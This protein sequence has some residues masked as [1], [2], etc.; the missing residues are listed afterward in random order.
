MSYT[1]LDLLLAA[2]L[3]AKCQIE[4]ALETLNGLL[5]RLALLLLFPID[6]YNRCSH[7]NSYR[8]ERVDASA[9]M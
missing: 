1:L 2:L 8:E 4:S 3:I 5:C 7:S 6:S 9:N